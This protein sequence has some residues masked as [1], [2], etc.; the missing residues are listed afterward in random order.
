LTI[1]AKPIGVARKAAEFAHQ[2]AVY[3][4]IDQSTSLYRRVDRFGAEDFFHVKTARDRVSYAYDVALSGVAGLRLVSGSLEML[5][6][7]GAP[8]LATTAPTVIDAH[9]VERTGT[10]AVSGCAYDTDPS[11]P[12]RRPVTAP[13]SDHCRVTFEVDTRGLA[14]PLLVDPAWF[15]TATMKQTRAW[16][17]LFKLP[18]AAKD[19]GKILAVGGRGS[20]NTVTMLYDTAT[21]TWATSES[22]K[23]SQGEGSNAVMFSDGSVLVG[24]GVNDAG[25]SVKSAVQLRNKTTGAWDYVAAMDARAY[26]AAGIVTVGGVEQAI[27]AGGYASTSSSAKGLKTAA[28]YNPVTDTWTNTP[29][30]NAERAHLAGVTLTDG[31][32]LLTGGETYVSFSPDATSTTE[33]YDPAMNKWT[34]A[35][36]MT[37]ARTSHAM[38]ALPGGRALVAGGDDGSGYGQ[39]DTV[40]YWS[41]T[42]WTAL[43]T[44]LSEPKQNLVS[45]SL[46]DGRFLFAGGW[47]EDPITFDDRTTATS[48]LVDL[49]ATPPGTATVL[50]SSTMVQP[51]AFAA[52]VSL[53][54][55]VLVSG[56]VLDKLA[57][58]EST[59]SEIFDTA[60]G[61]A[62]GT[63]CPSGL[64]CTDGVCCKT[65]TCGTGETCA[66]PG[67]EGLCT[68]PKGAAC[69][70]ASE[71]GTGY[72]VSGVCCNS[73][74]GECQSCNEPGS[75]GTCVNAKAGTDPKND[76]LFG[77]DPGCG[78]V[79][80]GAGSC[81]F[82][83]MPAGTKCGASL[84]DAG[85]GFCESYACD[86]FGTCDTGKPTCGLD[87]VVDADCNATAMTCVPKTLASG[88]CVIDGKCWGFADPNPADPCKICDPVAD[89][90]NWSDNS[91]CVDGG[92]VDSGMPDTGTDDTGADDTGSDDTG[93]ADTGAVDTGSL[94]DTGAAED[95]TTDT[96]APTT[97]GDLPEGKACSCDVP[98]KS[99]SSPLAALG[100]ALGLALVATRRRR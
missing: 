8:R 58:T 16:H 18:A 100:V 84:S 69:T 59:S 93:T 87:C 41:G 86:G 52:A 6:A 25:T 78:S 57:D 46:S 70:T 51:R 47:L 42:A 98:G 19:G 88:K 5:D 31:R 54:T 67:L 3:A 30:L 38:V 55:Q 11:G 36:A 81:G 53:G 35:A 77:D 62:C 96:G 75:L 74:C 66:A 79:C 48:D 40:E 44:K 61:K 83:S 21:S 56:G 37:A 27:F 7:D 1:A 80:D 33:I 17:Q 24:G 72:C 97:A 50:K 92:L 90:F 65:A 73:A 49:G 63:G 12:W 94:E 71:C 60:V 39:L 82:T 95:A 22:L 28:L 13:G 76:C 4:D 2:I 26:F 91:D 20:A 89:K 68:K 34:T 43:T 45:A 15:A 32:F 99:S 14:F 23:E 10:L 85:T 9:G 29:A 64:F